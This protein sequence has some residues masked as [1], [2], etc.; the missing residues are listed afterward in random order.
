[1]PAVRTSGGNDDKSPWR[2]KLIGAPGCHFQ[3]A[4]RVEVTAPPNRPTDT[5]NE[6]ARPEGIS[7]FC[8]NA[9]VTM[10]PRQLCSVL[11]SSKAEHKIRIS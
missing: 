3:L 8:L 9:Y 10:L 11:A 5:T 6:R 4:P 1:M 7:C 2:W